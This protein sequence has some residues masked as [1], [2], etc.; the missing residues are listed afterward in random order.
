MSDKEQSHPPG[1][2]EGLS[3]KRAVQ[4]ERQWCILYKDGV[5][6]EAMAGYLIVVHGAGSLSARATSSHGLPPT[7]SALW[8][9]SFQ[10][11]VKQDL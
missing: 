6:D 4:L 1:L 5:L 8:M 3:L 10:S 9:C 11:G 2:Y 7:A